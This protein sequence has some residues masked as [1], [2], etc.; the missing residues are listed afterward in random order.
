MLNDLQHDAYLLFLPHGV[1]I[2]TYRPAGEGVEAVRLT[3]APFGAAYTMKFDVSSVGETFDS[4]TVHPGPSKRIRTNG[5][6]YY[7]PRGKCTASS[8]HE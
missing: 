1:D 8:E 6:P 2:P 5:L 4:G 7:G 3:D